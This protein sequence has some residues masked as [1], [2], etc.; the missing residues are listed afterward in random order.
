MRKQTKLVAVLST[1]AL[2]AIGA[3]MTSFAAQGW[4]EEDATWVYY[5][6]NGDK[7]TDSWKKSGDNWY[8]LDA[9]GEMATD[10]LV[11]DDDNY[12]YVDENGAMVRNQWVAIENEDA[13][14]EDEPD[15]YWYYFQA[16][17]KAYKRSDDSTTISAKTINGKKYAFDSDGKMLYG[18]VNDSFE[19]DDE[20]DAWKNCE[21]YFG[22]EDD[23]AM[24]IG[25]QL[26][27]IT[28]D[29]ADRAQPGD[30]FWDE[31]QDR[32]FYF[33]T[34]GKKQGESTN[35]KINGKRYGFDESGRMV[36]SWYIDES[37]ASATTATKGE[38]AG[39]MGQG[40]AAYSKEFMYFSNPEDGARYTKGWFKVVPG[41]Y[42][43][44]GKYEEDSEYWYYADGD[45]NLTTNEIKKIKGKKYGF[46][47]YGRMISGLAL[48]QMN[49]DTEIVSK[50]ANDEGDYQYETEDEFDATVAKLAGEGELNTDAGY[51]FYYFGGSDDGAMKTGKQNVDLDGETVSFRFE[52][53]S[54]LKGAG[55]TGMDDDKY[56]LGGKLIKADKED[57]FMI[58][59]A[60]DDVVQGDTDGEV[61]MKVKDFI[62]DY[63]GG[64][65]NPVGEDHDDYK[66]DARTWVV[67]NPEAVANFRVLNSSG[68]VSK[69]KTVKDGDDYKITVNKDKQ[70]TKIT[71]ED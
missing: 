33:K 13:G 68:T 22:G 29:E 21:Y 67:E 50:I 61:Q 64:Y 63:C 58:V 7:V 48:L 34:S 25:W 5:D 51:R 14:E 55:I 39:E 19:R 9:D 38:V 1:A 36:A 40:G 18:W 26:I 42:L 15:H 30:D 28:D 57:K 44:Q 70:I 69:S 45:G 4:A 37:V 46:D 24:A 47:N 16:N 23:G 54:N 49:G 43:Q 66:K 53:K 6:K 2:L 12:Y 71:L 35:K 8:W 62:A 27:S 20:D 17:G 59:E 60:V 3:S 52:T 41:Y 65:A 11:E 10:M 32:W 31:D 56:Y